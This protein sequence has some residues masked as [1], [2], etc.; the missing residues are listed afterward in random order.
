[1]YYVNYRPALGIWYSIS[2]MLMNHLKQSKKQMPKI[3]AVEA[4]CLHALTH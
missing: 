4:V 1:M 3:V 2:M